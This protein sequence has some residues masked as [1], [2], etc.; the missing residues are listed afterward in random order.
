[1]PGKPY[2]QRN[3]MRGYWENVLKDAWYEVRYQ[4]IAFLYDKGV[5][6]F[7]LM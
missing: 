3:N 7:D 2:L 4:V 5:R 6:V 1:M